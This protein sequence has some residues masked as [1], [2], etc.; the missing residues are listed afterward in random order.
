MPK[1]PRGSRPSAEQ[2][3]WT[4]IRDRHLLGYKFRQQHGVGQYVVD[5]Y[6][7]LLK[8]A[9]DLKGYSSD[10]PEI[11]VQEKERKAYLGAQGIKRIVIPNHTIMKDLDR[12]IAQILSAI[13][14]QE[15][16][17]PKVPEEYERHE[18]SLDTNDD[19]HEA[20]SE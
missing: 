12:G 11:Q 15:K 1:R 9:I 13:A 6:C 20:E 2:I 5:F 8:L 10:T 18:S 16:L 3:L 19:G 4:A 17:L 14:V 7:P